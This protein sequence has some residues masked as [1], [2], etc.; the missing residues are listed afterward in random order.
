MVRG[1]LG[2]GS[3]VADGLMVHNIR[4]LLEWQGPFCLHR[5]VLF[6]RRSAIAHLIDYSIV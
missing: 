4:Y 2:G 6:F 1:R 5:Y 3:A